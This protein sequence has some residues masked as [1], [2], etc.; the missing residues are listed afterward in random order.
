MSSPGGRTESVTADTDPLLQEG[1]ALA[2]AL[3]RR[4]H[5]KLGGAIDREELLAIARPTL[6]EAV[7]EHDPSRAPFAPYVVMRMKW[8]M[9][10]EARR[11]RRRKKVARRAAACAA[12]ELL[13]DHDAREPEARAT[14]GTEAD[15]QADLSKFLAERAGAMVL[16][17]TSVPE[18]DRDAEPDTPEARLAN[19]QLRREVRSAVEALP[20]RQ[21]AL[22]ERYYFGGETFEA[23]ATDL[24]IS[25][26]WA[27]RVHAQA[28]SALAGKLR[29][30][31]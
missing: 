6:I 31:L 7:R 12:L 4:M 9:L 13:A 30:S 23:I 29:A 18:I 21:R 10:T 1:L 5:H 16:G 8:A 20:D 17:L 2:E 11:L 22:V 3:A 25:K 24:G 14:L 15:Y 28:M 19:E 26:S 27:S